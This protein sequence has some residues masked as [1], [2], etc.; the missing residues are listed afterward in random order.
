MDME[1]SEIL[2]HVYEVSLDHPIE[3]VLKP[4][5]GQN[6]T[7]TSDDRRGQKPSS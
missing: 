4:K 6:L 7:E 1:S 2:N 5:L 3:S